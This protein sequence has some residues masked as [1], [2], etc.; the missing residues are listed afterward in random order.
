[1]TLVEINRAAEL[2][3]ASVDENANIISWLGYWAI[4]QLQLCGYF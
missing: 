2:I 1:M 3:Y 4:H